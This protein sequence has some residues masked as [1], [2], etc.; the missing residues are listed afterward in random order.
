MIHMVHAEPQNSTEKINVIVEK[1]SDK[2]VV[3]MSCPGGLGTE[4]EERRKEG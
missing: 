1:K 4:E 2:I 3:R